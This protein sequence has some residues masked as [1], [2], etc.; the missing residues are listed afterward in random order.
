MIPHI[1]QNSLQYKVYLRPKIIKYFVG[2]C[3]SEKLIY[4]FPIKLQ[5][6]NDFNI[7]SGSLFRKFNVDRRFDEFNL[8]NIICNL[9][10]DQDV[11]EIC[12]NFWFRLNDK[13]SKRIV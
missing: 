13:Q 11:S 5:S 2:M 8:E 1:S 7:K 4:F 3:V 10:N 6:S 12:T 9:E